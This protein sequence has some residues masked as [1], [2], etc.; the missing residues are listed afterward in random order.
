M[1]GF[2]AALISNSY[3]RNVNK[4]I[5]SGAQRCFDLPLTA[6]NRSTD[7]WSF[8]AARAKNVS[9]ASLQ[10]KLPTSGGHDSGFFFSPPPPPERA[11][12][13]KYP[14]PNFPVWLLTFTSAC[15]L[16]PHLLAWPLH[17]WPLGLLLFLVNIISDN[18]RCKRS[19]SLNKFIINSYKYLY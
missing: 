13:S 15:S 16:P 6:A 10:R 4:L 2:F 7:R 17:I 12:S 3:R 1:L 8:L 14:S 18:F 19:S 9:L 11:L 5:P